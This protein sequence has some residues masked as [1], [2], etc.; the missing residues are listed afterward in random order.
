M[1]KTAADIIVEHI[2][3]HPQLVLGLATGSTPIETYKCLIEDHKQNQTSY[4]EVSTFNLDEYIGLDPLNQNSYHYYMK[5]NFFNYI[6]I[7]EQKTH[8]PNGEAIDVEKECE[9]YEQQ[10]ANHDG[11][12]LQL[13]GLGSNGHIGF[14]EPGTSFKTATHVVNLTNDTRQ[15]NARFFDNM[16]IVPKKAITMGI[17]TIMKSK[18]ILLLVSGENK[19]KALARLLHG[20]IDP[21]FPASVLNQHS[22]VTIISDYDALQN[23]VVPSSILL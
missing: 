22:Q 9:D 17:D 20:Q 16:E 12:D 1:S 5:S 23:T 3:K 13:L 4:Q 21:T 10:I 19:S 2:H 11:I 7:P 8:I 14:N 15:A 18:E 6:N